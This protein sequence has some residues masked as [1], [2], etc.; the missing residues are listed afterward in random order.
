MKLNTKIN[1]KRVI[2]TSLMGAILIVQVCMYKEY[3]RVSYEIQEQA[4]KMNKIA[5]MLT[6]VKGLSI[7]NGK[8]ILNH[9]MQLKINGYID[10]VQT[11]ILEELSN[12]DIAF[13]GENGRKTNM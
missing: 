11:Q 4:L 10:D 1:L 13:G 7:T 12:A 2:V 8:V 6:S 9:D 3:Q 5:V